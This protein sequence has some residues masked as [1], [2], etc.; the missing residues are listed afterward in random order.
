MMNRRTLLIF[1]GVIASAHALLLTGLPPLVHTLAALIIVGVGPALLLTTCLLPADGHG[2]LARLARGVLIVALAYTTLTIGM[3]LISYLP[4]GVTWWQVLLAY[5]GAMLALGVA[6]WTAQ[7][8]AASRGAGHTTDALAGIRASDAPDAS[9]ASATMSFL[10]TANHAQRWFWAGAALL[11]IV[12]AATRLPNLGYAEFHGDEARA[13][14]RG[15]AV[16]QG[17]E[18]VLFIHRKGPVEIL[19]PAT[20]FALAGTL[21]EVSAR[22][23]FALAGLAGIF[24]IWAVGWRLLNPFA[25]WLAALLLAVT[26]YYVAF[27]RFLQYQ[28]IVILT[29]AAAILVLAP[30][31]DSPR[32]ARRRLLLAAL[33]FATALLAHYD[34]LAAAPALAT[35]FVAA[36]VR[37]RAERRALLGAA[38]VAGAAGALLL[39]LYY[40]PFM[41]N[42][43][44]RATVD[45]LVEDRIGGAPP[46]NSLGDLFVRGAVYNS[47]YLML[48]LTATAAIGLLNGYWRGYGRR[49]GGWL[50]GAALT[51]TA[52]VALNQGMVLVD[53]RDVALILVA[54]P[55]V[56]VCAAPRLEIGRRTIWIWFTAAFLIFIFFIARPRTHVHVFFAPWALLAGDALFL[57]WR[58]VTRR[59]PRAAGVAWAA[60]GLGMLTLLFGAYIYQLYIRHD[61]EVLRTWEAASPDGYWTP[62]A[63]ATLDG[64]FG[65]P[66]ANGWKVVGA[67]YAQGIIS[68][69]FETNQRYP[70]VPAWYTRGEYRCGSTAAWYFAVNRLEPWMEDQAQVAGRLREQGYLPWGIVTIGGDDRMTIYHQGEHG[71]EPASDDPTHAEVRRLALEAFAPTFDAASSAE[72]PLQHPMVQ[73]TPPTPLHVTFGDEIRLEGYALSPTGPLRPGE[74]F[75]LT[76]YW[77]AIA[78]S[79]GSHKVSVQSFYGDGVMVAQKDALPVCDR[80][81]TTTW[82]IGEMVVDTHDVTVAPDAPPGVYP[83]F[84]ALYREEGG[85]RLAV[86]GAAGETLGDHFQIG[87]LTIQ[88]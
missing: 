77:R 25:G 12:G 36:V 23:P 4:G 14:L 11:L 75:R 27:A 51:L 9:T 68:G 80:E 20:I 22:L 60:G 37:W 74:T 83:L 65:F 49:W 46:Y 79:T 81:P 21:D 1:V 5:D 34:A 15:A 70:W 73:A 82:E 38:A 57:L 30:L 29:T 18:E 13:V 41:A 62:D 64:R 56:L 31:L 42:P 35:L 39:A 76:L 61:V 58:L 40:A 86:T 43:S 45:Y 88:P 53:G 33:L 24:A 85:A 3:L 67:L 10:S 26:G 54:L 63:A 2:A 52:T 59:L 72:L 16:I 47:A 44:F 55:L 50:A 87:A 78:P 32:A 48:L 71:A 8:R 17:Y 66:F 69:S 6:C 7:R 19:A 84:V 28:S